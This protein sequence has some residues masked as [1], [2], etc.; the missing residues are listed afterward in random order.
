MT[1]EGEVIPDSRKITHYRLV[2]K[3]E[4]DKSAFLN[5]SGYSQENSTDVY[6]SSS[7]VAICGFISSETMKIDLFNRAVLRKDFPQFGLRQGD[8]GIIVE[9]IVRD[10]QQNGYIPEFFDAQGNTVN[11]L[12]FIETDLEAPRPKPVLTYREMNRAA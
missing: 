8:V 2:W 9:Q 12:P 10:G 5:Q 11:V 1:V 4:S 3:A 7:N 6:S